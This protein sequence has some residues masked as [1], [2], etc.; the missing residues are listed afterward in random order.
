MKIYE[1]YNIFKNYLNEF[2]EAYYP[3]SVSFNDNTIGLMLYLACYNE[4]CI[5]SKFS[6]FIEVKPYNRVFN[7]SFKNRDKDI[8]IED[9][10]I[11]NIVMNFIDIFK[12]KDNWITIKRIYDKLD[13]NLTAKNKIFD[14]IQHSKPAWMFLDDYWIE[15]N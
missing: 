11:Y 12:L 15:K 9:K 7:F 1:F 13:E 10:E 6:S 14:E 8:K 5:F 3:N 2:K 4:D